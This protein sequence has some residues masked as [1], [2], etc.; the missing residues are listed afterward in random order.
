MAQAQGRFIVEN[1]DVLLIS[2]PPVIDESH[3]VRSET[4][5]PTTQAGD[6]LIFSGL[7][8]IGN[9]ARVTLHGLAFPHLQRVIQE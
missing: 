1:V 8:Q 6:R 4:I 7:A 2:E 9:V 3:R 5:M